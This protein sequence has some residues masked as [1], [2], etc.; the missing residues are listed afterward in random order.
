MPVCQRQNCD[1]SVAHVNVP[2]I[3]FSHGSTR[4]RVGEFFTL[5]L[6]LET[7]SQKIEPR[8]NRPLKVIIGAF[9]TL[10]K[11]L[12]GHNNGH[13]LLNWRLLFIYDTKKKIIFTPKGPILQWMCH[14]PAYYVIHFEWG[15]VEKSCHVPS[16]K[17]ANAWK[18]SKRSLL[19]RGG[20]TLFCAV[21]P[22]AVQTFVQTQHRIFDS[23]AIEVSS[24]IRQYLSY[25]NDEI[26]CAF[27]NRFGYRFA[28]CRDTP[29]RCTHTMPRG[30]MQ[31][32][33]ALLRSESCSAY[34]GNAITSTWK[35]N[36]LQ[37]FFMLQKLRNETGELC[38][39][40]FL[41]WLIP[42]WNPLL[43]ICPATSFNGNDNLPIKFLC[44]VASN[45]MPQPSRRNVYTYLRHGTTFAV[46]S[47]HAVPLCAARHNVNVP[48]VSSSTFLSQ[49][50]I[51]AAE[52]CSAV[53]NLITER[54]LSLKRGA[55][56]FYLQCNTT[57]M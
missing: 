21:I 36:F 26:F 15:P 48:L 52:Q 25:H 27:L 18:N 28:V 32:T 46:W 35:K 41:N 33:A 5:H 17:L 42:F 31:H 54:S 47:C 39:I 40:F 8:R 9:R 37:T 19:K 51:S 44:G 2:L 43:V 7:F 12:R 24:Q 11:P 57:R 10:R 4:L 38:L 1:D 6:L 55:V 14:H 30:R 49:W 29:L 22:I 16:K 13:P 45:S 56:H 23:I 34:A 50:W 3:E 20:T 53:K